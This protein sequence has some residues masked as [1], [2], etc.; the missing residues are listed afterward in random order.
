VRHQ[1]AAQNTAGRG[2]RVLNLQSRGGANYCPDSTIKAYY[3]PPKIYCDSR[4][5]Q[6]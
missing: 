6:S 5:R 2:G 1:S 3:I 4:T